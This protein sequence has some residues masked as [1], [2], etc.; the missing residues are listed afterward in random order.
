MGFTPGDP[1]H[2]A[3]LGKGTVREV[4]NRGR[5]VVEIKGRSMI[6]TTDQLTA[7][8]P[9]RPRRA[10]NPTTAVPSALDHDSGGGRTNRSL[11]LHGKTVDEAI[12]TLGEFLSVA[13]LEGDAQ[14]RIIHGRSGGRL[15]AAVHARLT[16]VP[17]VRAFRVDPRNPG[18]TV[19][20]F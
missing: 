5:Y 10:K 18:V 7:F 1:V 6:V 14:V 17:S 12:D 9:A 11:D 4:R 13:M 3:T 15:K 20:T 19:V 16:A 8:E 2:V